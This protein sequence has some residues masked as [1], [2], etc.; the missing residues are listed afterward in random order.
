MAQTAHID[1]NEP[2]PLFAPPNCVLLPHASIP[3]H[4][5]EPRYRAMTRDALASH[6]LIAMATFHGDDWKDDY[7]GN[8]P[9]RPHV[10]V[11]YIVRH[12]RLPGGRFNILLQGLCRAQIVEEVSCDP[13]RMAILKATETEPVMEIDMGEHRQR[14]EKLLDDDVLQQLA[15]VSAIH[16]WLSREIPTA[17]LIDLAIMT[18]C[19]GVDERYDMLVEAD[20][21]SRA[22]WLER[23]LRGTRRT[24]KL[25]SRIGPSQ[26]PDGLCL[27]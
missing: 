5:F 9:L 27:N 12:E 25:A 26:S 7:Q 22:L 13:Y 15:S 2:I 6:N 10:C 19:H 4:I 24:L 11:G 20:P 8:P 18:I 16:N 3:L 1:F 17:A 14:I 21:V 23:T